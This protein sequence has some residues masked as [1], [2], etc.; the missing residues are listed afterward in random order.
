MASVSE[1]VAAEVL[2]DAAALLRRLRPRLGV[3]IL[4]LR[5]VPEEELVRA[6][7]EGRAEAVF[8]QRGNPGAGSM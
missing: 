3:G 8:V 1:T 6:A 2:E 4:L 7:R 5:G